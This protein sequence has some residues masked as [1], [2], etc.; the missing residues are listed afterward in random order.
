MDKK[1]RWQKNREAY[2]RQLM[3]E[4]K[5]PPKIITPASKPIIR[6]LPP[7]K[8]ADKTVINLIEDALAIEAE[9]AKE[10]GALG[11]MARALTMA[12]LPHSKVDG[13]EFKRVNGDFSLY[14]YAPSDIGIP[15]GT[16]PRII[17][18]WVTSE[19]V[20]TKNRILV[21]GPSLSGFLHELGLVRSGGRWGTVNRFKDQMTRLLSS[22]IKCIYDDDQQLAM[23]DVSPF[24]D[25]RLWW[26]PKKP[27]QAC[28]WNSTLI[29]N[30]KFFDEITTNPVPID[31]RARGLNGLSKAHPRR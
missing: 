21:L 27:D 3:G 1:E 30:E 14:I 18:C 22:S 31:L 20:K 28:L 5:Q 7:V 17:L 23:Q 25:A 19:A 8:L 11:F 15:Y 9:E 6:S 16:M 2:N 4:G 12:T 29:L 13:N 10:A 26:D 24:S